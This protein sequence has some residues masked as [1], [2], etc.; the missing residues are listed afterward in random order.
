MCTFR[1]VREKKEGRKE[2][3]NNIKKLKEM[4]PNTWE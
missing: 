2:K 1:E 3:K 4:T